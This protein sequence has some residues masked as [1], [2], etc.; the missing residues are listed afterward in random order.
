MKLISLELQGFKAFAKPAFVDLNADAAIIVATN[1]QGKTS[2]FDSILWCLTGKIP[3][4]GDE[5][6]IISKYSDTGMARVS[7]ALRGSDRTEYR[8]TRSFD[9]SR[10]QLAFTVGDGRPMQGSGATQAI[11]EHLWPNALVTKDGIAAL[12]SALIRGVYLQQ[13]RVREFIEAPDDKERFNAISELVGIGRVTELQVQL[14]NAKRTWVRISNERDEELQPV[15]AKLA[16]LNSQLADLSS[17]AKDA[18]NLEGQWNAWWKKTSSILPGTEKRPDVRDNSA[19]TA[20]GTTLQDLQAL[21]NLASRRVSMTKELSRELAARAPAKSLNLKHLDDELKKASLALETARKRLEAAQKKA[22]TLRRKQTEARESEAEL[23]SL[24]ELALRHLTSKCPVCDQSINLK[25]TKGRLTRLITA[26]SSIEESSDTSVSKYAATLE[27]REQQYAQ[28]STQL[29]RAQ[30]QTRQQQAW[31]AEV[32]SRLKELNI[33]PDPNTDIG[34]VI[35][36]EL[37]SLKARASTIALQIKT[38]E[39]LS[40]TMV[41]ASEL[42]KRRELEASCRDLEKQ[43]R[44][45]E[46]DLNQRAN[47]SKLAGDILDAMRDASAD[48]VGE[49]LKSIGPIV[50]RVYATAD[51]H[52]AFSEVGFIEAMGRRGR[53]ATLVRDPEFKVESRWPWAILSSSQANVLA[54]AVF[55][56]FSIGMD[57]LPI[58]AAIL[59][60]PLQ[61]LDDLNLLGLVDFLRRLKDSRQLLISTHEPRFGSLLTRKLRP[62]RDSQRTTLVKLLDWTR[63]GPKITQEDVARKSEYVQSVA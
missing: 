10:Q 7:V 45:A 41:L 46:A 20:L 31:E 51:P 29:K 55:L 50:Q 18:A 59:D 9:G 54:V 49:E 1:G 52:P 61:S 23:R 27:L 56:A 3:R 4:L 37:A 30:D 48:L 39:E 42:A 25:A 28:M 11:L 32:N 34:A 24:A 14:E 26:S 58:S 35:R 44:E 33:S 38:G 63:E 47:A 19:S 40:L 8:I 5:P 13:D 12:T 60:D 36:N 57:N 17:R 22:A 43:L 15:R 53:V 6:E 62:I 21:Q 2:L 16:S